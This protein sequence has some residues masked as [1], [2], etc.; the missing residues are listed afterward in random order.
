MN[1]LRTIDGDLV[2]LWDVKKIYSLDHEGGG[3]STMA[4]LR[5]GETI[6]ELARDYSIA[7]L[8]RA[9]DPV[10]ASR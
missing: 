1:F 3:Y 6:V 10:R 8:A 9:L 5:D 2:A 4:Q 7:T